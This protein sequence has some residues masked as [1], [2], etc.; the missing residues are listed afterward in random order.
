MMA[1][2]TGHSRRAAFVVVAVTAWLGLLGGRANGEPGFRG[3]VREGPP[4]GRG[5][6][7]VEMTF[8][9]IA[10][11]DTP[12]LRRTMTDGRGSYE[13]S[14]PAGRYVV[15]AEHPQ[16]ETYFSEERPWVVAP[17]LPFG[18]YS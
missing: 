15:M 18:I 10:N 9:G 11:R 12:I 16:Y 1:P 7:Q 13:V 17:G 5:I 14:L 8:L 4:R 2:I 3:T 6:P